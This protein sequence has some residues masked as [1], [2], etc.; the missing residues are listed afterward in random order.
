M[1]HAV[2][3]PP[4][5]KLQRVTWRTC[6][7]PRPP[8]P[9]RRRAARAQRARAS[10]PAP[11]QR[12]ACG[13]A[14]R[15]SCARWA[16]AGAAEPRSE[17]RARQRRGHPR[18]A[19][20]AAAAT[21]ARPPR[22]S[23]WRPDGASR[24]AARQ[25]RGRRHTSLSL[26]TPLQAPAAGARGARGGRRPRATRLAVAEQPPRTLAGGDGA[27]KRA[28]PACSAPSASFGCRLDKS[29]AQAARRSWRVSRAGAQHTDEQRRTTPKSR[30]DSARG[31]WN[32]GAWVR[33]LVTRLPLPPL[34][35]PAPFPPASPRGP[36]PWSASHTRR[37]QP[38]EA[39]RGREASLQAAFTR[40]NT[41]Q[42]THEGSVRAGK[43]THPPPPPLWPPPPLPPPPCPRPLWL[44]P[45]TLPP[46]CPR[47]AARPARPPPTNDVGGHCSGCA[48]CC[49]KCR[50]C[51]CGAKCG[52]CGCAPPA[53]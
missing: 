2:A 19:E 11:A 20:A 53:P 4:W 38:S 50:C 40:P 23:A 26:S 37:C 32:A 44:P 36:R 43:G 28:V 42:S 8:C 47:P 31:R 21:D 10:A 25:A 46:P 51:A 48:N 3:S 7:A 15:R 6:A 45:P 9:H 17:R 24:R 13:A 52:C 34:P 18:E 16:P 33:W 27:L 1:C 39:L 29:S 14:R 41:R 35:P 30:A 22:S 12:G 5:R 49:W